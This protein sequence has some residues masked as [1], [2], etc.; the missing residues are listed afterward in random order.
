M[1]LRDGPGAV[2][3][4]S[5]DLLLVDQVEPAGACVAERLGVPFVTVS[6]ALVLTGSRDLSSIHDWPHSRGWWA[7]ARNALMFGIQTRLI[8]QWMATI[9]QHRRDWGLKAYRSF[10]ESVSPWAHLSQQPSCFDFPRAHL[11]DKL[12]LHRALARGEVPRRL[13]R[14]LGEKLHSGRPL[15]YASM[16]TLQNRVDRVFRE[17][18]GSMRGD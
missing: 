1:F 9:N 6:P 15:I 7:R 16:G 10:E 4:E 13:Y 3:R 5:I 14:F 11:P 12:S 2:A 8:R 17:S 18:C